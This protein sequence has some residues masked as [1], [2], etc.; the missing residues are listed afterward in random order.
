MA[1][2][3]DEVAAY[4]ARERAA[5]GE[6]FDFAQTQ[7]RGCWCYVFFSCPV[8][9]FDF[10]FLICCWISVWED[11][12]SCGQRC[13]AGPGRGPAAR[14]DHLLVVRTWANIYP[15]RT[16]IKSPESKMYLYFHF[17]QYRWR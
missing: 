5:L 2:E 3:Q 10:F 11:E 6:S 9:V 15:H 12:I 13:G 16:F 1:E 14:T 8:V 7:R 4:L 17:F